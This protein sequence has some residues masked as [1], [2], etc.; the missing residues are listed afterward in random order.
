[1]ETFQ[2]TPLDRSKECIRLLRFVD[3]PPTSDLYH[4]SLETYDIATAPRFVALSYTRGSPELCH[5]VIVN[6]SLLS[7]R[8]NLWVALKAVRNFF[9][10]DARSLDNPWGWVGK[11][12]TRFDDLLQETGYPLTW[13]DAI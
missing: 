6:G 5:D 2:H 11:V 8:E 12:K 1:M 3:Q 9:P 13:I 4:F 7:I 10:N